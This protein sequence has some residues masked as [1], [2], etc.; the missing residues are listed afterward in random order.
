MSRQA[1]RVVV[2]L[3]LS[4]VIS[5]VSSCGSRPPGTVGASTTVASTDPC[6][7]LRQLGKVGDIF[8]PDGVNLARLESAAELS[9]LLADSISVP[10]V[11]DA[12]ILRDAYADALEGARGGTDMSQVAATL[13]APAVVSA[14]DRVDQWAK[15]YCADVKS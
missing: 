3:L 7:V 8:S 15:S 2:L 10:V 6:R 14:A 1:S 5:V 12:S 9:R 4:T 11:D 13:L